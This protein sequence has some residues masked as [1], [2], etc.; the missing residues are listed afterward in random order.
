MQRLFSKRFLVFVVLVVILYTY[1]NPMVQGN[2]NTPLFWYFG[3]FLQNSKNSSPLNKRCMFI[4][5]FVY[6]S[7]VLLSPVEGGLSLGTGYRALKIPVMGEFLNWGVGAGT[8]FHVMKSFGN[9][10][11]SYPVIF[12]RISYLL[13]GKYKNILFI[14]GNSKFSLNL[15]V[16]KVSSF[17]NLKCFWIVHYFLDEMP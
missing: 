1:T 7:H 5:K 14:R 16:L 13:L 8:T 3:D 9:G 10:G 15:I 11:C 4:K 2:L 12:S 6:E 17:F